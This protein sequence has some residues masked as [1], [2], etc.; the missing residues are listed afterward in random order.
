[1]SQF[2]YRKVLHQKGKRGRWKT[3]RD[4]RCHPREA[5]TVQDHLV[6]TAT[7]VSDLDSVLVEVPTK[8]AVLGTAP[9]AVQL[10]VLGDS[11]NQCLQEE[12]SPVCRVCGGAQTSVASRGSGQ[13]R[14]RGGRSRAT[15]RVYNMSQQEAYASPD[16]VT[17]ILLV[18]GIPARVLI[19]PG[20]VYLFVTPSF[21]HN[22]NVRLSAL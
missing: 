20:V 14:R 21:A 4:P 1:M 7:E 6:A 8:V 10:E 13:Q 3:A 17:G 22:A 12:S 15:G 9:G 19:N 5:V 18:F 11:Y 2:F 16:V